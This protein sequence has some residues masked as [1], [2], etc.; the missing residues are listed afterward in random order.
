[1][2]NYTS[3]ELKLH[4]EIIGS[5]RP[6]VLIMGIGGHGGAWKPA[7]RYLSARRSYLVPDNRGT[8][9]S[10]VSTVPFSIDDMAD[11]V[12]ALIAANGGEPCDVVGYSMGGA[13]AQSLAL[14]HPALVDRLV[15]LAT[16]ATYSPIQSHWL[17]LLIAITRDASL[18]DHAKTL[19]GLAWIFTTKSLSDHG[20]AGALLDILSRDP[21][22]TTLAGLE[23]QAAAIRGFDSRA[24]LLA[25]EAR[26]LVMVG[27]EDILTPVHQSIE[28]A[29][30]IP[31]ARL[32]VLPRG[33][34]GLPL[35][36]PREFAAAVNAFLNI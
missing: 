35:E 36:Y 26:T 6:V 15:L 31:N 7:L 34:H 2:P 27:A 16:F 9:R 21:Y 8:G 4:Y 5:G 18:H 30:G 25:I 17:D 3:D 32:Q 23:G 12:A 29:A 10:E 33:G 28:L 24:D 13:V 22:P 1:M 14:R 11:D 20:Q 19:A